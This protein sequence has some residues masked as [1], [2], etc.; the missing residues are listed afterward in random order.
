MRKLKRAVAHAKMKK[1][2]YAQVN[3]KKAFQTRRINGR[4]Q[5]LRDK[6]FFAE[7]W[8]EVLK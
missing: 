2:G 5:K 7:N 1:Q 8:K 6:S 4:E 3:K